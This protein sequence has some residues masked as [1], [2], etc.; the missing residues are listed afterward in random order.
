MVNLLNIY[1]YEDMGL[2]KKIKWESIMY[3][4]T[5]KSYLI[6]YIITYILIYQRLYKCT[7]M[8]S[9]QVKI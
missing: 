9:Y 7:R 6:S 8:I 2:K 1:E 3:I 4:K 5:S